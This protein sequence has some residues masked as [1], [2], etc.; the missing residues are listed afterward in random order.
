MNSNAVF[1][2]PGGFNP[3]RQNLE[4]MGYRFELLT[5]PE[6]AASSRAWEVLMKNGEPL[7]FIEFDT[8]DESCISFPLEGVKDGRRFRKDILLAG[9]VEGY[10]GQDRRTLTD[11]WL[12]RL[13][14]RRLGSD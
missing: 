6:R 4:K 9:A 11:R 10:H 12:F 7:T 2:T 8:E 1:H 5:D 3:I 13:Y 14:T